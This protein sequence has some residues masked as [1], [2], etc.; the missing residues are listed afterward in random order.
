MCEPILFCNWKYIIHHAH[1]QYGVDKQPSTTRH[2][3]NSVSSALFLVI[4]FILDSDLFACRTKG[5]VIREAHCVPFFR[6][7]SFFIMLWPL[8]TPAEL[9]EFCFVSYH[10]ILDSNLFTC[11]LKGLVRR[12]AHSVL[13]FHISMFSL[14]SSYNLNSVNSASFLIILYLILINLR[15]V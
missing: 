10:L 12:E 9:G 15:V 3:Q 1:G 7:L 5:L 4:L 6:I 13:F 11:H 14:C 2:W 8:A